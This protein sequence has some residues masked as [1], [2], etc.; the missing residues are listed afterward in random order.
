MCEH[1]LAHGEEVHGIGRWHTSPYWKE[2][3]PFQVHIVD[4]TDALSVLRVFERARPDFIY[5]LASHAN[6]RDSFDNSGA[7]IR[8]NVDCTYNLLDA[9]RTLKER[10]GYDPTILLCSCHDEETKLVSDRGLLRF[11]EIRP[12][13]RALTFDP[14]TK[15]VRWAPIGRVVVTDYA[16]EMVQIKARSVDQLVTPNHMVMSRPI[17]S[18]A[19]R[20]TPAGEIRGSTTRHY[21]PSG[22]HAGSSPTTIS[23]GGREWP[24]AALLYFLGLYIGDGYSDHQA[25]ERASKTGLD[26]QAWLK[27]AREKGGRF[28][29]IE[30]HGEQTTVCNSYRVFLAIPRADKAR[31]RAKACITKLGLTCREYDNE[32]YFTSREM[33]VGLDQF[34]HSAHTKFIPDWLFEFD[35]RLLEHLYRGMVDSDGYYLATGSHRYTTVSARL[36]DD[37][38]KLSLLLGRHPTVA[39]QPPSTPMIKGRIINS[40]GAFVVTVSN[41]ERGFSGRDIT[42]VRYSG[43]VWCLEIDGTH[44]FAVSRNGRVCFSGNS[45][46]V[47][48][49]RNPL[50]IAE[51]PWIDEDC[52]IGPVS[53][54]AVSKLC[55][56]AMGY[57]WFKSFGLK[58]IRTRMF[59]YLNPR[60]AD[61]FATS[62]AMQVAR[63]EAG[64]QAEL[65]HG[66]LESLRTMLDVRD[67]VMAY[68]L[69]ATKCVPGEVYNIGGKSTCTVGA[70]LNT[71]IEMARCPIPI[72]QDP[73]LMRPADVTYQIPSSRKFEEATGWKPEIALKDSVSHLLDHCRSATRP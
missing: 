33:V 25:R 49:Q 46:E 26:R 38:V 70:F 48:G 3:P 43:K 42:R 40:G 23:F 72:R 69:A 9:I 68:H 45:S 14:E 24:A 31:T 41:Q 11:D 16:G 55:Q 20:F 51:Y 34:T 60:R 67:A 66:N 35:A 52:P 17:K 73:A 21:L 19:F 65:V 5:H 59:T 56:D 12:T 44:N 4:L 71:L 47:Y 32:L 15:D 58:V 54:Y 2:K 36:K 13:D 53:P 10:D 6:V 8:N 50:Q 61:L 39:H 37:F 62:F 27:T 1:L 18:S 57:A 63:I 7:V 30:K 29:R 28:A 22:R 64:L